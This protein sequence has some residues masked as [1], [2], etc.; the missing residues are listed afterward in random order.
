ML[1]RAKDSV[2][3]ARDTV[4]FD[5]LDGLGD[6]SKI[7]DKTGDYAY[8]VTAR[9]L[10]YVYRNWNRFSTCVVFYNGYTTGGYVVEV[11][12]PWD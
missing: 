4:A 5:H 11:D 9:E 2:Q 8:N 12:K 7:L 10:R 1:L 3:A 6:I